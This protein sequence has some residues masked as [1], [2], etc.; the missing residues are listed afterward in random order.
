MKTTRLDPE[1]HSIIDVSEYPAEMLDLLGPLPD[2]T[3]RVAEIN[4]INV[5]VKWRRNGVGRKLMKEVTDEA[6]HLGV[7]L[8]LFINPYGDMDYD[9]L[10]AWY[11]RVGF[12]EGDDA[13]WWRTPKA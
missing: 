3:A 6:D 12:T 9:A 5:P 1:T 8:V 13:R 10:S 11:Q 7:T 4:R 2:G